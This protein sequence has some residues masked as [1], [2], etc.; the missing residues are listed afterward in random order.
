MQQPV[1][2]SPKFGAKSSHIFTQSPQNV[3][4]VCGIDCLP[5]RTKFF[6]EQP[7]WCTRN[8]SPQLEVQRWT[9]H[10]SQPSSNSTLDSTQLS[11]PE[12]KETP[13][14]RSA[15]QIR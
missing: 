7:S 13:A 4:G 15:L 14:I 11:T 9:K 12:T 3:T 1:L 2:L 8:Y 5:A 6:C 10:A